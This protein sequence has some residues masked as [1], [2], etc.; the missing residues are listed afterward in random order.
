VVGTEDDHDV[1]LLVVDQVHGLVDGVR[2]AGVPLRAEPLLR[3]DRGHVVAEQ[4]AHPPGGGDVAVQAVAL[5][6]GEHADLEDAAVGQVGQGEVDQPV[7]TPERDR[8]LGPVGGQRAQASA[9]AAGEDDPKD[10]RL[11]H[12][13][14]SQTL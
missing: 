11:R 10:R 8:R 4:R 2:R 7:E 1:R 14:S 9:G 12:V 13:L 6:L 5:V 3:R